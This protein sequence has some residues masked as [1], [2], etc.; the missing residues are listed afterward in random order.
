MFWNPWLPP[1]LHLVFGRGDL[2]ENRRKQLRVLPVGRKPV[3]AV[4][5]MR[6]FYCRR[7]GRTRYEHLMIADK[8]KHFTHSLENYV[9]DLFTC[10]ADE[11]QVL[12]G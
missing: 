12:L 7:C 3:F 1:S 11:M 9:M 5:K 10:S 6:R 2:S 4:V 8:K